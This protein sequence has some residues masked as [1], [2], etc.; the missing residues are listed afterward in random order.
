MTTNRTTFNRRTVLKGIGLGSTVGLLGPSAFSRVGAAAS[1]STA[2][3]DVKFYAITPSSGA[4][5]ALDDPNVTQYLITIDPAD[6]STEVVT[7]IDFDGPLQTPSL[8][9]APDGTLYGIDINPGADGQVYT[10]DPST[11]TVSLLGTKYQPLRRMFGT[12][13]TDDGVYH[14]VN[15]EVDAFFSPIDYTE[16]GSGATDAPVQVGALVDASTGDPI[17]AIHTGLT[18]NQ[19]TGM[20]YSTLGNQEGGS[21][22]E[23]AVI[24]RNTGEVTIVATDVLGV[25]QLVGAEFNP[26]TGELYVV[27]NGDQFQR[28]DLGTGTQTSLGTLTITVDGEEQQV[29]A[30]NLAV[31][32]VDCPGAGCTRTIGYYKTHGCD[33][34]G[35]NDN[36]VQEILDT[37]GIWLGQE[38]PDDAGEPLG[39][40]IFVTESCA[41]DEGV[42]GWIAEELLDVSGPKDDDDMLLAQLLAAKLN[43]R[44][45][46]DQGAI[47]DV[48]LHADRYLAGE[49]DA[50]ADTI[51]EWKDELDAYNNGVIGPGHCDDHDDADDE[52]DDDEGMEDEHEEGESDENDDDDDDDGDDDDDA[53]PKRG[54]GRGRDRG[55]GRG[56]D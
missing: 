22:D 29:V 7:E 50:D 31:K 46:A 8:S 4:F 13:F 24:D 35:N 15:T 49:L 25:D 1:G 20:I 39:D 12:T 2:S 23:V 14:G 3:G 17:D 27:R 32:W 54:R 36:I 37:G 30:D 44:D 38:D 40:S 9:F 52:G 16:D 28:F 10:V 26:C 33:P 42:D 53:G 45:G 48:V 21:R 55:R 34:K 43:V 47:L 51:D 5:G 56:G 6:G 18:T 41:A 19:S 11:G